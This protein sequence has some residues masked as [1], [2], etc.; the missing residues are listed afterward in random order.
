MW[1]LL[2]QYQLIN[3]SVQLRRKTKIALNILGNYHKYTN[4]LNN[5]LLLAYFL[6]DVKHRTSI[7]P[8]I[9][10]SPIVTAKMISKSTHNIRTD[11]SIPETSAEQTTK[12]HD[13]ARRLRIT[14]HHDWGSRYIHTKPNG[15]T[16]QKAVIPTN[17]CFQ[18]C[19]TRSPVICN[20]LSYV[21]RIIK[22]RPMTCG[23]RA[24]KAVVGDPE[25]RPL[26]K[27][28]CKSWQIGPE[29]Q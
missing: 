8:E 3:G 21:R 2:C 5:S 10:R 7:S 20:S 26:A 16:S 9:L 13:S 24:Y 18:T 19:T 1:Q 15:V 11:P 6:S 23:E 17:V 22:S 29:K 4:D 25:W 27:P 28:G 14:D 12:P